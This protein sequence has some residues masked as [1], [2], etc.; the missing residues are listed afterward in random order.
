MAKY[1]LGEMLSDVYVRG[2]AFWYYRETYVLC[3]KDVTRYC[4]YA[5]KRVDPDDETSAWL[6]DDLPSRD[7]VSCNDD[8][9]WY[10]CSHF[11]ELK[12]AA[13]AGD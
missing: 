9:V 6:F 5:S 12:N 11:Y 13:N 1:K 7:Y 2:E 3:V 10:Y 8:D 4:R